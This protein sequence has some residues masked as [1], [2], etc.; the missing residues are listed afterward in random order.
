M[1][2]STNGHLTTSDLTYAAFLHASGILFVGI[3]R[4]DPRQPANFIFQRPSDEVIAAWQRGDD[5]VSARAMHE[6]I[7]FLNQQ[8]RSER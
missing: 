1:N 7:R 8:L 2:S 3:D 5:K 4:P 6:A